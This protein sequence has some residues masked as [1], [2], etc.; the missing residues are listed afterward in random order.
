MKKPR[1]LDLFCGAGGTG[2]GYHLAGWDVTGVDVKPQP[3]YP[4]AFIERDALEYLDAHGHEYD[5]IHASP[6]CQDHSTLAARA[7]THGTG[8][9]LG[10]TR[11]RL[12]KLD[13]PWVIENV[14]GAPLAKPLWLCGTMFDLRAEDDGETRWLKRHRGFEASLPLTAPGRCSCRGRLIGGVYG[15]GG[16]GKMTRGFK[17]RPEPA[18]TAMGIDWMN[19]AELSQAIPPAYTRHIGEQLMRAYE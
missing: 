18:A 12:L 19:R 14:P 4:L 2:W 13:R 8:W 9:L 6:P 15:T 5:A 16:G 10:A 7:G 11:E 3:R 17:F 1:L